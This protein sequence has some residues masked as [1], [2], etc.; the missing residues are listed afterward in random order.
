MD[1]WMDL[2]IFHLTTR[3]T[4]LSFIP[5]YYVTKRPKIDRQK[6]LP[7]IFNKVRLLTHASTQ[8]RYLWRNFWRGKGPS[9]LN[10]L[11]LISLLNFLIK[12]RIECP[13]S[14]W[15]RISG[16]N[17]GSIYLIR[18]STHSFDTYLLWWHVE[19]G[20][21]LSWRSK[22]NKRLRSLFFSSYWW[23]FYTKRLVSQS[24]ISE[25]YSKVNV[26]LLN[27]CTSQSV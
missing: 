5:L 27:L 26:N 4:A 8:S 9:K 2:G 11:R 1:T 16:P 23:I 20:I 3:N 19:S 10:T 15:E 18:H 25:Q 6:T 21:Y 7:L 12:Y 24:I 22:V 17:D 14:T 13:Y